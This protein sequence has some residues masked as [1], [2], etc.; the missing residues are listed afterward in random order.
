MGVSFDG[1]VG[2]IQFAIVE[3]L[4]LTPAPPLQIKIP[5][6]LVIIFQIGGQREVLIF[7]ADS[8]KLVHL[9]LVY[10]FLPVIS[11]G[12]STPSKARMVGAISAKTPF[13]N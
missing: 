5:I 12:F 2:G 1:V 9:Y 13:S 3:E 6:S 7:D 8:P 4:N 11:A 10:R